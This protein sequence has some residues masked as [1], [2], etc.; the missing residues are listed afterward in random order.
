LRQ[1]GGFPRIIRFPCIIFFSL[2]GQNITNDQN[3]TRLELT[4]IK[5][6]W[7][8]VKQSC[9]S[10]AGGSFFCNDTKCTPE[11]ADHFDTSNLPEVFTAWIDSYLV[12]SFTVTFIGIYI[13]LSS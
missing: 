11:L 12:D 6:T 13:L 4:E 9:D 7:N 3:E 2:S 8:G 1:V 10:L 5:L